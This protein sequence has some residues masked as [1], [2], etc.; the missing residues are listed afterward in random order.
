MDKFG[1]VSLEDIISAATNDLNDEQGKSK[2]TSDGA[3]KLYSSQDGTNNVPVADNGN[4]PAGDVC[5]MCG[6]V[7]TGAFCGMCGWS[8]NNAD[9]TP[10]EYC[11]NCGAVMTGA[12]CQNCGY[13]ASVEY[14][15]NCGTPM[16]NGVCPNCASAVQEYCENC[17]AV[18]TGGFCQNCGYG[19]DVEYCEN[20]GTPMQNGYC[21]NCSGGRT[22]SK[23]KTGLIAGIA[24]AA[25]AVIAAIVVGVI[26]LIPKECG[27]C[28]DEYK[29]FAHKYKNDFGIVVEACPECYEDVKAISDGLEEFAD[30]AKD[31]F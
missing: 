28:G 9:T 19:A 25:V 1:G 12:F 20:C 13:G 5:K 4:E 18:M 17:G 26:A 24:V 15:E 10:Q 6:A 2:Q 27:L 7:M 3:T 21:P 11:E 23:P 16:Q 30:E 31:L 29:G 22:T 14:C 8:S